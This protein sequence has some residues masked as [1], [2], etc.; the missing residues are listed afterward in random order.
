VT[1]LLLKS[2]DNLVC[3]L[4]KSTKSGTFTVAKDYNWGVSGS[5]TFL[6]CTDCGLVFQNPEGAKKSYSQIYPQ[7]YGAYANGSSRD[8]EDKINTHANAIRGRALETFLASG[9]LFD[10]GCGS[11]FFLKFMKRRGWDV[12]GLD[13]AKEHVAFAKERLKIKNVHQGFWPAADRHMKKVDA[14]SF[15]HVIEHLQNPGRALLEAKEM[16][17]SGGVII[18]ETPNVESWP[19]RIF[20]SRALTLDAPRHMVLFSL[21]TLSIALEKAGFKILH[22][23]TFSPS[24]LEYTESIRYLMQ[25]LGLRKRILKNITV[26]DDRGEDHKRLISPNNSLSSKAKRAVHFYEKLLF[27]GVNVLSD[28]LGHGCNLMAVA[29][30]I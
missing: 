15:L 18:I 19:I 26:T 12:S 1:K 24:T 2:T 7:F 5:F 23:V 25:D 16:M 9:T 28:R 27:R 6:R 8:Y 10:V 29:K 20:R 11:G 30:V 14:V 17:H 4:C 13:P 21:K 22:L 3:P